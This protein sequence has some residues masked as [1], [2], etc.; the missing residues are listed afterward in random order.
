MGF[1]VKAALA[2]AKQNGLADQKE[3]KGGGGGYEPPAEGFVKLRLIGYIEVGKQKTSWQGQEKIKE[4]VQLIWEL[5]G[6]K[7]PAKVMDDGTKVPQRITDTMT[8]SLNE[9]AGFFKLF[10]ELNYKGTADN[11]AELLGEAFVGEIKHKVVGEGEQKRVYANLHNVRKPT[12]PD[13]ETGEDR[14]INVDP[15]ISELRMHLW[16][17][18]DSDMWQSIYID[19]EY[20]EK[21]DEKT[22]KVTHPARSKNVIQNKIKSAV[23]WK[24]HPMFAIVEVGAT[25][26]EAAALDKLV[27]DAAKLS[28]DSDDLSGIA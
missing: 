26:E 6:P 8:L 2:K 21:V 10:R 22:G 5:S 1:D 11:M 25:R 24:D 14:V 27:G 7:H 19:G 13:P 3:A 4:Q 18:C 15:P 12:L 17:H 20:P 28:D 23:N 16:H 9:K